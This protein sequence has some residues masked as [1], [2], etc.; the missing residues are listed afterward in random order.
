MS[1]QGSKNKLKNAGRLSYK[2]LRK[3]KTQIA[4]D[5]CE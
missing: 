4:K 3:L 2:K 5:I 1:G